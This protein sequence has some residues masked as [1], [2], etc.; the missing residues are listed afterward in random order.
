MMFCLVRGKTAWLDLPIVADGCVFPDGSA[1]LRW[2]GD[3]PSTALYPSLRDLYMVHRHGHEATA[4]VTPD[5][6]A[7]L[8]L[9]PWHAE[10]FE[11]TPAEG[12]A[13][14]TGPRRLVWLKTDWCGN[15]MGVIGPAEPDP[16]P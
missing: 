10:A 16:Q 2:R 6:G 12:I 4:I 5:R 13:G 15:A 1:V 11:G 8:S 14:T 3:H 9:D 7:E